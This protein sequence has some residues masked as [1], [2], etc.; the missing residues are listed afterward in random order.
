MC[1]DRGTCADG[2]IWE[3]V[4]EDHYH[5]AHCE[6]Y[7]VPTD[8]C[9]CNSDSGACECASGYYGS[10]CDRHCQAATTCSGRGSCSP[11]GLCR[12]DPEFF[13]PDCSVECVPDATC[14]AHGICSE[15]DGHCDCDDGY[16]GDNCETLCRDGSTCSG[17]GSCDTDGLCVCEERFF[18]GDCNAC[19]PD[20]Y[21]PSCDKFC[22]SSSMCN[23]HGT[24][25]DLGTCD[26]CDTHFGPQC[27]WECTALVTCSGNGVCNG[28]GRCQCEAG[29]FGPACDI[30]CSPAT[31]NSQ[32]TC[33]ADG[34]CN[35]DNGYFGATCARQCRDDSTCSGHGSCNGLG[36]C[37]CDVGPNQVGGFDGAHCSACVA[38][39]YGPSC[40]KFCHSATMCHDQGRCDEH[41]DCDC[42]SGYYGSHCSQQCTALTTCSG[43]GDCGPADGKCNC[44]P[45]YFGDDCSI[46]CDPVIQC[47]GHGTCNA[48]GECACAEHFTGSSCD[49]CKQHRYGPECQT[50]CSSAYCG[51]HGV[52]ND[53]TGACEC[54]DHYSGAFCDECMAEHFGSSCDHFCSDII[55]LRI[56]GYTSFEEPQIVGEVPIPYYYD[57]QD[58]DDL[59]PRQLMNYDGQNPVNYVAG[60]RSSG[61][62]LSV[63]SSG[64]PELGFV[65]FYRAVPGR[66]PGPGLTDGDRI[67]VI[68]DTTTVMNGDSG[69]GGAA[70]DGAQ[71]YALEETGGFVTIDMDS[72]VAAGYPAVVMKAFVHV[73]SAQWGSADRIRIWASDTVGGAVDGAAPAEVVLLDGSP[74]MPTVGTFNVDTWQ[75]YSATVQFDSIG[76]HF[77]MLSNS[78]FEQAWFDYF[79]IVSSASSCGHGSCN[80]GSGTCLCHAGY[81]GVHC[82]TLCDAVQTCGGHGVCGVDTGRCVCDEGYYGPA[83]ATRCSRDGLCEGHGTCNDL[84]ECTCDSGWTGS[85]CTVNVEASISPAQTPVDEDDVFDWNDKWVLFDIGLEVF[86]LVFGVAL[87]FDGFRRIWLTLFM[88]GFSLGGI[89]GILLATTALHTDGVNVWHGME[90]PHPLYLLIAGAVFGCCLGATLGRISAHPA[91]MFLVGWVWGADMWLLGMEALLGRVECA[92]T[93]FCDDVQ[94][95]W[96]GKDWLTHI[97]EGPGVQTWGPKSWLLMLSGVLF[98]LLTGFSFLKPSQSTRYHLDAVSKKWA[99]VGIAY[100]GATAL[101][102]AILV[103]VGRFASL[104]SSIRGIGGDA[105]AGSQAREEAEAAWASIGSFVHWCLTGVL[106]VTG[107]CIQYCCLAADYEIRDGEAVVPK[108]K[109][110]DGDLGDEDG[111][112]MNPLADQVYRCCCP[113]C[114]VYSRDGCSENSSK[115]LN[116]W[117]CCCCYTVGCWEP[118]RSEYSTT[119]NGC[120]DME[121]GSEDEGE[122]GQDRELNRSMPLGPH[123]LGPDDDSEWLLEVPPAPTRAVRLEAT[124]RGSVQQSK[125]NDTNTRIRQVFERSLPAKL[126]EPRPRGGGFSAPVAVIVL[127]VRSPAGSIV[128][129]FEISD[130]RPNSLGFSTDEVAVLKKLEPTPDWMRKLML[131]TIEA[132]ESAREQQEEEEEEEAEVH[133]SSAAAAPL[134]APA[135]EPVVFSEDDLAERRRAAAQ[136]RKQETES[137]RMSSSDDEADDTGGHDRLSKVPRG[138]SPQ[139]GTQ[140]CF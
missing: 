35:C 80:R 73:E 122:D 48:R 69:Q 99:I 76:M 64:D 70:P 31:C 102:G 84:G 59:E 117:L 128:I 83:C 52:C 88:T 129:D 13:G 38:D 121:R 109:V 57:S 19:G 61:T 94:G 103:L 137:F 140:G 67:G 111:T 63:S 11:E 3:C 119:W 132:A 96:T 42:D 85:A 20:F 51:D 39:Y 136:R 120:H 86:F 1:N 56:L 32:G 27:D 77:G 133:R 127:D 82:R 53:V 37:D 6:A 87:T 34:Q 26:C 126:A 41:G 50:F 40:K 66:S 116:S 10:T 16:F 118:N 43:R 44:E 112:D 55:D 4:C 101:A 75:E 130:A 25:D 93:S 131:H 30:S 114:S 90:V 49:V 8:T 24:C 60:S 36:E 71:Y 33:S 91:I 106:A 45:G 21:G 138:F 9:T 78:R 104:R 108:A 95:E 81:Y 46:E 97:A 68:G 98:S 124:V 115:F 89:L 125:A 58:P 54:S 100:I 5:G 15:V 62:S 74:S 105:A 18:G 47:S 65:A 123:E 135:P 110:D 79:R 7:C 23:D 72:V 2:N 139:L 134:P 29:F 113:P 12:C 14:S 22:H 17:H 92:D 28:D 107:A